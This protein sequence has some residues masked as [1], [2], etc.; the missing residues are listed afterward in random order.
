MNRAIG[1]TL[2]TLILSAGCPKNESGSGNGESAAAPGPD[3]AQPAIPLDLP[4]SDVVVTYPLPPDLDAREESH[5][6]MVRSLAEIN[7][8]V[9]DE[10]RYL[11]S[12]D[13][14]QL[15]EKIAA[16]PSDANARDRVQLYLQ[17][18][19]AD[20]RLGRERPAIQSLTAAYDLLNSD[21]QQAAGGKSA[22]ADA[23]FQ[24]GVAYMRLAGD[25]QRR[26]GR[27]HDSQGI[28]IL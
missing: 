16:L 2:L 20:L 12:Q 18:G 1:L 26:Q 22:T 11:G 14:R 8:R 10:N 21:Q 17:L 7:S 24:L 27:K 28:P 25:E 23:A 13:A 19:A 15:R 6:R 9:P 4:D 5:Q 3:Q